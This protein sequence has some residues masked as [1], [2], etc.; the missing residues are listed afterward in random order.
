MGDAEV[1][2]WL[3][4]TTFV[5]RFLRFGVLLRSAVVLHAEQLCRPGA[6][7]SDFVQPRIQVLLNETREPVAELDGGVGHLGF[8][9]V[10]VPGVGAVVGQVPI[11]V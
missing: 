8:D 4:G 7:L 3:D 6:V 9:R 10:E 11:C 5:A 1:G 2:R